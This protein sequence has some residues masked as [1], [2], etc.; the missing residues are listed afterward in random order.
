MGMAVV[1]RPTVGVYNVPPTAIAEELLRF[2]ESQI[3]PDSV[4]AIDIPTDRKNWKPRSYGR[5]QFASLEAKSK[6]QSLSLQNKLI[7]KSKTLKIDETYDDIIARPVLD[8]HRVDKGVLHVGFMTDKNSLCVVET[9]KRVRV[10][11]MPERRRVEFWVWQGDECY[12]L[13][14]MFEDILEAD[15]CCLEN[16]QLDALLLKL[17]YGPRIYKKVSGTDIASKFST[18]RYHFC[19]EDFDFVWV[20]TT[21]F[22]VMKSI[23]H[24]TSFCWDMVDG[25]LAYDILSSFPNYREDKID[26]I[27]EDGEE[28]RSA[29]EIVP[30][31]KGGSDSN[32]A[33]NI[34][35][36]L[37]SLVHCQKISLAAVDIDLVQIFGRLPN[38]TALMIFQKLH[39]L[40]STCFD[41]VSFVKTQLFV[42]NRSCKTAPLSSPNSLTD[43]N[44]MSFHRAL[45]TP[46]KI[47][48]LGP[49]LETSNYVVKHFAS[50]ASDFIRV[51]FVEEDWSKLPAN[52]VSTSIHKGFFAKPFRTTIYH[53]IL[54]VL[55]DGIVIGPKRFE[56]LAFSA[57]QLRS[58]S[59][60]MFASNENVRAKDIR[61]WMGCY[62]K[63]RSVSKCA[64]RMGQLFSS[65]WQTFNVPA[66]EVELIPDI[67]VNSE[68]NNYCFSDGIG[69]ISLSFA[70]QVA[71]KCGLSQTPSAFQIR[72]GG[73]KGVI[74]V[75]RTSFRKLS[76]RKSMLK[77][78]SENTMLNV[79]K[80][81]ESM[82]SYLNREIVSL[83]STL[84][85]SDETFVAL[86]QTQLDLLGNMFTSRQA[87]LDV[88]E[89]LGW[90]NSRNFLVKMLHQGYEPNLEP[91][92]SMMLQAY[93]E[94]MLSDLRS[95]SRIYV[96]KGRILV[97]CLDESGILNYG[98]VYV[99][100]TMTEAELKGGDQSFFQR[101]DDTTS[102][103]VGKVVVTKNP[104]L[105]P[106]DVRVLDAIYEVELEEKG[107]LDCLVFPQKGERPH[108]NE[109]SGGDL[110]G[111]LF[112]ISWDKDLVPC[113]TET[114]MDYIA[115]RPRIMDHD[116]TLE[117]IHKFFVDYMINDSLGAISTAHLVHA[118]CEP[119]KAGSKKCL[120]LADLHSMA[121]DYAKTGAPAEMPRV[122]K[123]REFPD[124]MERADKPMYTSSRV[125]GILYRATLQSTA[126]AG[127]KIAFHENTAEGTYDH[128][129][130]VEGFKAFL[131]IA[132]GHKEMYIER[133]SALMN[134]YSAETEDEILT[135]NLRKKAAYLQRDNRRYGEMKDRILLAVKSL[136]REAKE[137][138]ESNCK[139]DEREQ[140]AS[141]WYHVAYHPTYKSVN[142]LSFP[143]IVGD[144]LSNIKYANSSKIHM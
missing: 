99:R 64:A 138:F 116:V 25:S 6:A 36:Q 20:R 120:Q 56:F 112:F 141:A 33:Y 134:Y 104:C 14:I 26:L 48:C 22:S 37:N 143:W 23:G 27:L 8:N 67:E 7:F 127:S 101:V 137:W 80:W 94:N 121:V 113:R 97:G 17:R 125:L 130:E 119:D 59:V 76:L 129:L 114:P 29:S 71:Q 35:F 50:Y 62:N 70:R 100:V 82:P 57:S 5:V 135:G 118:D 15:G 13:D 18:D 83:L 9:F 52:A 31:V 11:V 66:R 88:L 109:C 12:K 142:C 122:L 44:I 136:Q 79:T 96:P 41:P 65:S 28:F 105:H 126:Q 69:K 95:R 68:G 98:Q 115:R 139:P 107:L 81:S 84:G 49:E 30:V 19:K 93:H 110:D 111:D 108:P 144:I 3:G 32:L 63:I 60:W 61:E 123:P 1:E 132:Q 54:S 102:I 38:D 42:L 53:R 55:R 87:A 40:K 77:F 46:L 43:R 45:I 103:V 34:L 140:M 117:E 72:Y 10:W 16:A 85:V 47:Y 133:I 131:E 4:F 51:T 91:Y 21:D 128:H 39:K 74:A 89:G 24:S 106:G 124:F 92:L 90:A 86:Q 78:E 58:N 73:Y 2:L 75:D